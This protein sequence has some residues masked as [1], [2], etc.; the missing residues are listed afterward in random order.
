[1][2]EL[3]H[4]M[5]Q[6]SHVCRKSGHLSHDRSIARLHKL[7]LSCHRHNAA[8]PRTLV[9]SP[10]PPVDWWLDVAQRPA[11]RRVVRDVRF[12]IGKEMGCNVLLASCWSRPC[13]WRR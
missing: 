12:E 7:L 3:W 2:I 13:A 8:R 4:L 11:N 1:M 9:R 6:D 5:K 10:R